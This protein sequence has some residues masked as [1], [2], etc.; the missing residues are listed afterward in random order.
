M[1]DFVGLTRCGA[2]IVLDNEHFNPLDQTYASIRELCRCAGLAGHVLGAAE[3]V[4]VIVSE[5]PPQNVGGHLWGYILV[6]YLVLCG[7]AGGH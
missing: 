4:G 5:A 1:E 2:H 3:R 6:M 7:L